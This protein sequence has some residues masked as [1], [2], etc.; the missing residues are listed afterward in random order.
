MSYFTTKIRK[1]IGNGPSSSGRGMSWMYVKGTLDE[2][3]RGTNEE[4]EQVIQRLIDN[5]EGSLLTQEHT[6]D[7]TGETYTTETFIFFIYKKNGDYM[8][9]CKISRWKEWDVNNGGRFILVDY[10]TQSKETI[11]RS[12]QV[13]KGFVSF[14]QI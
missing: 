1:V 12:V 14:E 10:T 13:C 5:F 8:G 4:N 3:G 2:D 7:Q 11:V 6:H 9:S